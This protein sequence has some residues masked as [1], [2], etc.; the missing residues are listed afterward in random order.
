MN[1]VD[2]FIRNQVAKR[3]GLFDDYAAQV[4]RDH[5]RDA[6]IMSNRSGALNSANPRHYDV[7]LMGRYFPLKTR[8]FDDARI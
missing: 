8:N 6:A 2:T 1:T 3:A 5:Q 7:K 4:R